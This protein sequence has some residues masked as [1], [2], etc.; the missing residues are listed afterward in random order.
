LITLCILPVLS[1]L[2]TQPEAVIRAATAD[3]TRIA[4]RLLCR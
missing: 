3:I 2:T 4:G 1:L